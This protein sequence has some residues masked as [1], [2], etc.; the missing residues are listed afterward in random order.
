MP[1]VRSIG[2]GLPASHVLDDALMRRQSGGDDDL[3]VERDEIAGR[4]LA[5]RGLG[6]WQ[7]QLDGPHRRHPYS[8]RYDLAAL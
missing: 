4:E 5:H 3:A 6:Q 2:S 8:K 1:P 7:G